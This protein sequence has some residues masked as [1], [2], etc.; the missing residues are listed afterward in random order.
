MT[1]MGLFARLLVL[2]LAAGITGCAS[3]ENRKEDDR[4]SNIPWAKPESWQ[5]Q[6]QFGGMFQQGR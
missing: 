2:V 1:G 3:T 5:G 4:V 6:G